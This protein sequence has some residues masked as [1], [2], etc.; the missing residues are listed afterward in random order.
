[1][2]S[3][4][5]G[6]IKYANAQALFLTEGPN[7]YARIRPAQGMIRTG[8]TRIYNPPVDIETAR[9]SES[10]FDWDGKKLGTYTRHEFKSTESLEVEKV[11]AKKIVEESMPVKTAKKALPKNVVIT[12]KGTGGTRRYRNIKTGRFVTV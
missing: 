11:R 7:V 3:W 1:M 8:S 9:K 2:L 12:Y 10:D 6:N 5:V 4:K